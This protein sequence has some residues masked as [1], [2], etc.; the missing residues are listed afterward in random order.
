MYSI[1]VKFQWQTKIFYFPLLDGYLY[2]NS[3]LILYIF[4]SLECS[5][6]RIVLK[7]AQVK[8]LF[9]HSYFGVDYSAALIWYMTYFYFRIK[10]FIIKILLYAV[11][12]HIL[13]YIYYSISDEIAVACNIPSRWII[14][15]WHIYSLILCNHPYA[16]PNSPKQH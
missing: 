1:I 15:K 14:W 7:Q 9:T 12:F 2:P 5:N 8:K 4:F 13:E 3:L 11:T 6:Q 10:Y 16:I